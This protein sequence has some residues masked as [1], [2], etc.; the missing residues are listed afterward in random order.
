MK[1]YYDLATGL[2]LQS[3]NSNNEITQ[4]TAKRAVN[5]PISIQFLNSGVV[6]TLPTGTQLLFSG[7]QAAGPLGSGAYYDSQFAVEVTSSGWSGPDS[8]SFYT[9]NPGYNTTVLNALFGYNYPN[10]DSA[11]HPDSVTLVGEIAWL[12]PGQTLYNKTNYWNL[13]VYNDVSKGIEG[14]PTSGGA[15][16]PTP[17]QLELIAR[18]GTANG[19]CPLDATT[20]IPIQYLPYGTADGQVLM[21]AGTAAAWVTGVLTMDQ[22]DVRY[23]QKSPI[24]T[25][26]YASTLTVDSSSVYVGRCTL[27]GNMTLAAPTNPVD[28]A[29]VE[30]WLHASGA[31]RVVTLGSG[32]VLPSLSTFASPFTV[33]S[34]KTEVVV[35]RYDAV[36]NGGQWMFVTALGGY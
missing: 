9:C 3:P 13:I 30:L 27:T 23:V 8:N 33:P 24:A 12:L 17:D 11:I 34:G 1:V 25:L 26:T 14:I 7:K 28:G 35:L 19:Y 32:I 18:K 6:T 21:T 20:H 36:T 10:P 15:Q 22:S 16:Y 5:N 4:I 2:F 31:D 29:R